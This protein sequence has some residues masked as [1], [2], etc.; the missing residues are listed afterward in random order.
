M[1]SPTTT[2]K[3]QTAL[4]I[5]SDGCWRVLSGGGGGRNSETAI[6]SD[7]RWGGGEMDE[8]LDSPDSPSKLASLRASD[9]RT[10]GRTDGDAQMTRR[11][12]VLQSTCQLHTH[13]GASGQAAATPT[14][15]PA[16]GLFISIFSSLL[17]LVRI[18]GGQVREA[19][20]RCDKKAGPVFVLLLFRVG[21]V[22]EPRGER[23]SDMTKTWVTPRAID[24][25]APAKMKLAQLP[26]DVLIKILKSTPTNDVIKMKRLSRR[27]NDVVE[28]H[29]I[30]RPE[31]QEF[32]VES[33]VRYEN[34]TP[35]RFQP[36]ERQ[37]RPKQHTVL[38]MRRRKATKRI[39]SFD[40][41]EQGCSK[42][43]DFVKNELRKVSIGERIS[44]DGIV[45]DEEFYKTLTSKW[46]DLSKVM[47]FALSMCTVTID[48]GLF[49]DLVSRMNLQ[50]LIIEFCVFDSQ[51]VC[52]KLFLSLPKLDKL[53]I[54]P[55]GN[56]Y[57]PE[58]TNRTLSS[59][60]ERNAVPKSL[61]LYNCGTNITVDE[62]KAML[63]NERCRTE[64]RKVDWDL[65]KVLEMGHTEAA[66]LSL[67]FAEGVKMS[68]SDDFRSRRIHVVCE[69]V[70]LHFNVVRPYNQASAV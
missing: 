58:L 2:Q 22:G 37:G 29:T 1:D 4:R 13:G 68:S 9:G 35:G 47:S 67:V 60:I 33:R 31:V 43:N 36:R 62:L 54:Q 40:D 26:D 61:S 28:R 41:A 50:T 69:G 30:A 38:T 16:L 32:C 7:T 10:D 64:K 55:R 25:F 12:D 51:I 3:E 52:D 49:I 56:A 18:R 39:E 6:G 5:V 27:I 24:M 8:R 11:R 59:W 46:N 20:R 66:L 17:N 21:S 65:G 63:M 19:W 45:I 57:F 23:R 70:D 42:T 14:L 48:A 34:A 53:T 15:Q 44:L